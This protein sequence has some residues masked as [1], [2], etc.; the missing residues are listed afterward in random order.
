MFVHGRLSCELGQ[1]LSDSQNR[2]HAIS[3]ISEPGHPISEA[4]EPCPSNSFK[5]AVA[6]DVDDAQRDRARF[7]LAMNAC[8]KDETCM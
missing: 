8:S 3:V 5:L 2:L 1:R 6:W 4:R 7:G